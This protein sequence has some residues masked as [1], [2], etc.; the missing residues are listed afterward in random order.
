MNTP[1][2]INNPPN[3]F[4]AEAVYRDLEDNQDLWEHAAY[5]YQTV[6]IYGQAD[7]EVKN[8][9]YYLLVVHGME[10][11]LINL[12]SRWKPG[13]V[14]WASMEESKRFAVLK[15]KLSLQKS[16]ILKITWVV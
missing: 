5:I 13:K 16:K 7:C 11:Q 8:I 1:M 4:N 10:A 9:N 12:V 14:E 6:G 2:V 3:I 15:T